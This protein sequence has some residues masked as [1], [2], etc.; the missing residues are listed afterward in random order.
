MGIFVTADLHFDDEAILA[1]E[2]RPFHDIEE[3]NEQLIYRWNQKLRPDEADTIYVLGDVIGHI[4]QT[5]QKP[6]DWDTY[7]EHI[8]KMINRLY[9][10]KILVMGNHDRI[11]GAQNWSKCFHEV[12]NYPIVKDQY[13]IMSHEPPTYYNKSPFFYLYGHVHG[14]DMYPTI[15]NQSACV[16][17]E[18]WDYAPVEISHI[19]TLVGELRKETK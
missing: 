19:T 13:M 15:S 4:F 18:R 11:L 7:I 6:D 17:V 12:I 16:S 10:Y 1:Y 3:M 2:R 9:G 8:T 14:C 5:H